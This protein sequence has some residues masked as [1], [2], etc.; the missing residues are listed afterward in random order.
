[1]GNLHPVHKT[2]KRVLNST[3]NSFENPANGELPHQ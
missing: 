2:R 3:V 1:M